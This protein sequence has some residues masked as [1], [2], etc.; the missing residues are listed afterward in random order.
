MERLVQV[1]VLEHRAVLE[2]PVHLAVL[3][4]LEHLE[5]LEAPVKHYLSVDMFILNLLLPQHGLLPIAKDSNM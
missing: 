5:V 2:V 4:V 1:E 3:E